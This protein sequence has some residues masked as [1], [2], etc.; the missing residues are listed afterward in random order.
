MA[1]RILVLNAGSSSLKFAVFNADDLSLHLRGQ[2]EGIG[3]A[4]VLRS[5]DVAVPFSKSLSMGEGL[6]TVLEWLEDRDIVPSNLA[7]FGHRIVHGGS[8]FVSPIVVNDKT[9]VV[10]EKLRS[11]A[12][13]HLP[14]GLSILR[15]SKSMRPHLPH[16]ACFDTAFHATQAELVTRLPLPRQYFD[17][18]YKRYGFHG[19]NY[20]HVVHELPHTTA[21]PLPA[22]LLIAH[23]GSGASMC[24][25][26]KGKSVATTMGFSTADGLMMGTR[27]G[28]I[29]PGAIIAMMRDEKLSISALEDLLYRKSGLLG[30]SGISS[31]MRVLLESEA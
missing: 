5:G 21:K 25:V 18:G 6:A 7:A 13:L 8:Q 30:M 20:E 11:L 29:D 26:H 15:D 24:A 10:L 2:V 4:P 9:L 19:L 12:P 31:D 1:K 3:T 28:S 17:K 27:T 14:F 16:V 22:R 23:L